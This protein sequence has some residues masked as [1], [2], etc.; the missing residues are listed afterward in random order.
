METD[1]ELMLGVPVNLKK[2]YSF[3]KETLERIGITNRKTKVIT[4]SCYIVRNKDTGNYA[5]FHF[6]ELLA[7]DGFRMMVD[8]KDIERRNA[9][10]SML[11]NW[12]HITIGDA[13]YDDI[14]QEPLKSQIFVLAYKDKKAYTINHK[15][16]LGLEGDSND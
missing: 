14:Y 9:I 16:E 15:Y 8:T 4:P 13:S 3:V 6:K 11:I 5:I 12:G 7:R 1:Y 2:N 10:I